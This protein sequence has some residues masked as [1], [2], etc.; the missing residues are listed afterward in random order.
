MDATLRGLRIGLDLSLTAVART[1]KVNTGMLSEI[2]RGRRPAPRYVAERLG[3]VLGLDAHDVLALSRDAQR[4]Y[5]KL[6]AEQELTRAMS[7]PSN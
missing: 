2:E 1:I 5:R 3:E 4:E 7:G 6:V